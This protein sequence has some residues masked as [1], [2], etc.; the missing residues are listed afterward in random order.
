MSIKL[1]LSTL[2][3]LA[4]FANNVSGIQQQIDDA[5]RQNY[6]EVK[7]KITQLSNQMTQLSNQNDQDKLNGVKKSIILQ[8]ALTM[9][10]LEE[11]IEALKVILL[12]LDPVAQINTLQDKLNEKNHQVEN[13]KQEIIHLKEEDIKKGNTIQNHN[14][15]IQGIYKT[16]NSIL[17]LNLQNA[18]AEANSAEALFKLA[19]NGND[20][21]CEALSMIVNNYC[22]HSAE[23][24]QQDRYTKGNSA[25]QALSKLAR[26]GNFKVI[27]WLPGIRIA[28]FAD[29]IMQLISTY[30]VHNVK[31]LSDLA[32][33]DNQEAMDALCTL[34]QLYRLDKDS[35]SYRNANNTDYK[36]NHSMTALSNLA[37]GGKDEARKALFDTLLN[38]LGNP[39][40]ATETNAVLSVLS[41]SGKDNDLKLLSDL[42]TKGKKEAQSFLNQAVLRKQD[43]ANAAAL[44]Q[45]ALNQANQ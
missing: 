4:M 43:A 22:A 7:N 15:A 2:L 28:P 3:V 38:T 24:S 40:N 21:A 36:G 19:E 30:S 23:K 39:Q 14:E 27:K 9:S 45:I 41:N 29:N 35:R 34:A 12:Q 16:V 17:V 44:R 20:E 11:D 6:A 37:Q 25:W 18:P 42:V 26:D 31:K 33:N 5:E 1:K 13:L 10:L 32:N 8:G